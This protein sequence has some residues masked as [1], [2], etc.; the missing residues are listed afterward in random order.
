M[1]IIGSGLVLFSGVMLGFYKAFRYMEIQEN[2]QMMISV[3]EMFIGQIRTERATLKEAVCRIS[4][5]QSG[6]IGRV[7]QSTAGSIQKNDGKVTLTEAKGSQTAPLTPNQKKAHPQIEQSGGT[8][9][10]NK[11]SSIGLPNGEKNTSNKN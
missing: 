1:K 3:M 7:L 6:E 9:R 8:V 11:G 10:G 2:L 4:V 5:R